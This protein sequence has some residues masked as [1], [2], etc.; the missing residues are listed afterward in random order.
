MRNKSQP[1]VGIRIAPNDDLIVVAD[2][3]EA[4]NNLV[5]LVSEVDAALSGQFARTVDWA[6]RRLSYASPAL[7]ELEPIVKE[8]QPDNRAQI[9]GAIVR[10][11][12]ALKT[13]ASRPRYFSDQALNSARALALVLGERVASV[14]VFADDVV[15]DCNESIATNV[16]IILRPGK[17]A[18]GSIDG[19]LQALN[20]HGEFRFALFEPVFGRRIDGRMARNADDSL[21]D[22]IIKLYEKRVRVSGVIR[23]NIRGETIGVIAQSITPLRMD[24]LILDSKVIAGLFD[25]TGGLSA[26]D[27]VRSLRDA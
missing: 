27:Y 3:L 23:T 2:F 14:E 5:R 15:V 12:E 24:M 13:D 6:I 21:K 8:G 25:I 9:T 7:L 17:E 22:Q 26:E 19:H 18:P 10:G 4:A 16:R 11:L 20:S 1:I